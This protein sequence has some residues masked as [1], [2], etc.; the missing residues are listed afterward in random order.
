MFFNL[1]KDL[2]SA[3]EVK[4]VRTFSLLLV[5]VTTPPL[6]PCTKLNFEQ[7]GGNECFFVHNIAAGGGG[8]GGGGVGRR[9]DE[10]KADPKNVIRSRTCM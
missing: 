1:H 4:S 7:M 5:K 3:M 10:P 6:P 8:G 2:L 9:R